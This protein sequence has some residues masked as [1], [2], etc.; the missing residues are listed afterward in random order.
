MKI[1]VLMG[2]PRKKDSLS[3]CKVIEAAMNESQPVEFEY[4]FLKDID[5]ADCKG[6]D[7]CFAK[8]EQFCPIKDDIIQLRQ[9][10]IAA[11]GIIFSSPVYA[12]QVTG[13]FK[14]FVD[15]LSFM[16][17]RPELIGKPA[18]TLVTT[19]GGGQK[20]VTKYLTMT[21]SGWGCNLSGC[22]EVISAFYT[23]SN[24]KFYSQDYF[25]K[26]N[27]ELKMKAK[28]M[29]AAIAGKKLKVPSYFDIYMFCGM[30]SK[31]YISDADFRYW[32]SKGWLDSRYYYETRLG[33]GK[34]LFGSTMDTLIKM[35]W[36]KYQTNYV[37][38]SSN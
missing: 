17:H 18:L 23:K 34:K 32:Q 1:V 8:G 13:S 5:I 7:Q 26:K 2:S 6:C 27:K 31:T 33:P 22:I 24:N 35:M 9:K 10:L 37:N 25:D 29:L 11:D 15:R 14:R 20:Q 3:A 16:F 28:S 30:K 21:A 12:Y 36:K 38:N 19:F 4:V